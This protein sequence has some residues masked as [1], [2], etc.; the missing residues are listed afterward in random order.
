M[1]HSTPATRLDA[2]T[3]GFM[4]GARAILMITMGMRQSLGLFVAPIIDSTHVGYAAMSF[5]LAIGQL[6]WGIAQPLFGAM[7]DRHGP[8]R[9]LLIGAAMLAAG[10]LLAPLATNEIGFD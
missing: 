3:L 1:S 6:M 2:R 7:A 9:V 5:A 4:A 10:T 8:R